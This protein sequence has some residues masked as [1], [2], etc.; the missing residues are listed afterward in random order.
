MRLPE[1][2]YDLDAEFAGGDAGFTARGRTL[3]DLFVSSWNA[4]LETMV[5]DTRSVQPAHR[6]TL[7]LESGTLEMLLFDF[8]QELIFRKD[9]EGRFYRVKD[10]R[11]RRRDDRWRVDAELWGEEIEP[12]RHRIALDVKAVTLFHFSVRRT[13]GGWEAT[14]VLDV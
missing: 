12:S 13:E 9:A 5:Q 14:A 8:L 11:V 6:S 1:G 3:E 7:S 10:P 2:S 4:A